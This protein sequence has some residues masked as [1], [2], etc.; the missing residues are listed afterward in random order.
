MNYCT[1]C[2]TKLEL[3]YLENE[4]VIPYCKSCKKFC[5]PLFNVAISAIVYDP[6]G[7][8][9]VLIQQYGKDKNILVAGYVN[10]GENA[11]QTLVREVQEELHLHVTDCCYNMSEYFKKSNTLMLNFACIADSDDLSHIAKPEVDYAAWYTPGEAKEAISHGSLAEK[12]LLA[13]LEKSEKF[14]KIYEK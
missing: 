1:E 10:K 2:G 12:F 13:W 14:A 9:I 3:K 7:E 6:K 4:G 8:K 11:E 5:F